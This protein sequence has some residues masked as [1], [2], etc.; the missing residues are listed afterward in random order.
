[1]K[2]SLNDC[3][4]YLCTWH[5][6]LVLCMNKFIFI[7]Y[8]GHPL[9]CV[10]LCLCVSLSIGLSVCPSLSSGNKTVKQPTIVNVLYGN[11]KLHNFFLFWIFPPTFYG[12][13]KVKKNDPKWQKLKKVVSISGKFSTK[14][15]V[16]STVTY[17]ML[18][19]IY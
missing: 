4:I 14:Y 7:F 9:L 5:V 16:K 2:F 1:M 13:K 6:S 11:K 12:G 17:S 10:T 3:Y 15:P 18:A 8:L 19:Q